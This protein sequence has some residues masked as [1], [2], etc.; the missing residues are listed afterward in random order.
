MKWNVS[1]GISGLALKQFV[2]NKKKTKKKTAF[3]VGIRGVEGNFSRG[4]RFKCYFS[5]TF[6][7]GHTILKC[8]HP[9]GAQFF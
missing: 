4:G 7:A 9:A 6:F 5:K 1:A 8:V 3:D 2:I